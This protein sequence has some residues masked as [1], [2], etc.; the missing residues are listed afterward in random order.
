MNPRPAQILFLRRR[1]DSFVPPMLSQPWSS[2]L[3]SPSLQCPHLTGE[4]SWWRNQSLILL[5]KPT[6][7]SASFKRPVQQA[8]KA[9]THPIILWK[10]SPKMK[11]RAH[12]CHGQHMMCVC[13]VWSLIAFW[14]PLWIYRSLVM[15]ILPS[16]HDGTYG[17]YSRL[18][19]LLN[20]LGLTP[21]PTPW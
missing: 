4:N 20:Y 14:E 12:T 16:F 6:L 21:Q 13:V 17:N 19:A 5:A 11:T 2:A 7:E 3:L 18:L 8:R 15:S 1:R 9:E 10:P